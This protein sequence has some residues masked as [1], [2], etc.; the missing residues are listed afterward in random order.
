MTSIPDA[1]PSGRAPSARG[2]ASRLP[3]S[4]VIAVGLACAWLFAQHLLFGGARRE[5][6]LAFAAVQGLALVAASMTEWG[7]QAA[8]KAW[9]G[10]AAPGTLFALVFAVSLWSLTPGIP[11]GAN[12]IWTYVGPSM[13]SA[14]VDRGAVL[15]EL[16]RLLGLGCIFLTGRLYGAEDDRARLLFQWLATAAGLFAL[17][18]FFA[19]LI[20]PKTIYGVVS[21]GGHVHRLGAS[22]LSANTAAS[23]L[24]VGAILLLAQILERLRQLQGALSADRLV[25]NL[26][27]PVGLFAV[28]VA[29]LIL[30]ASRAGISAALAS[31][32]VFLVWEGI[33]RRW[34][35]AGV[36]GFV[37]ALALII[38]LLLIG[39]AGLFER[40]VD[41]SQDAELRRVINAT[42][43][44]AFLASPW[45]GYGLGSFDVIN[46][47]FTTGATFS[48][49]WNIHAA[50]NVYLQW[51][52]EGG[53]LTAAPMFLCI[54][55]ILLAIVLGS[56]RRSRLTTIL[57]AICC[58]S[59]VLLLHGFADYALQIPSISAF[60]A[61]ILGAGMSVAQSAPRRRVRP[62]SA[63][64]LRAPAAVL[65]LS[66][67]L[68]SGLAFVQ[69]ATGRTGPY[70]FAGPWRARADALAKTNPLAARAAAEQALRIN[71][72][73]GGAWLRRAELQAGSGKLQ[74]A[75]LA[76]LSRSYAVA[77]YD[78]TL[79]PGRTVFVYSHW[80]ELPEDL[81]RQAASEVKA[82]W[83]VGPTRRGVRTAVR[84]T[85]GLGQLTL[86]SDL[87]A[88]RLEERARLKAQRSPQP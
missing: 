63:L 61:F 29:A 67:V 76:S 82:F 68:L 70:P 87:F 6:A 4:Q 28:T 14:A 10:L 17:W 51:L 35:V 84:Q 5:I 78:P 81:R 75:A 64:K 59:L 15:S 52:E 58:A 2:R 37:A 34:R 8:P 47:L 80:S 1:S 27:A 13:A 20:D 24:G 33:S 45:M 85:H 53:V 9:R 38:G 26:A 50:H 54:A 83:D 11:G 41:V 46:R 32:A 65:G 66:C 18:A 7:V 12:P 48:T 25:G 31:I 77:P 19:F 22:F 36:A 57:R 62:D 73:D 21:R 40:A 71:P 43:R 39:G 69:V 30:T 55:A 23:L 88:L 72:G 3:R 74:P 16:L 44:D 60:W 56:L 86:A 79:L 49:L 42:H